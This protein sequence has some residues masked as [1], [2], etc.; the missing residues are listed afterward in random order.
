MT[1]RLRRRAAA[2][3]L[4][5]AVLAACNRQPISADRQNGSTPDSAEQVLYNASTVLTANGVRRGDMRGDTVG[6]FESMTR[7]RFRPVEVRFS[8][9]L[10]RPLAM[11]TAASGEYSLATGALVTTGS[12]RLVSDTS[13]RR[14]VTQAVL[15]DVETNQLASDSSFTATFGARKLSGVGFTSDPGL[16]TIQCVAKCVGSL[17]G[18]PNAGPRSRPPAPRPRPA[19]VRTPVPAPPPP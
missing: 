13:G 8:T 5:L 3:G 12:A 17:G 1:R 6:T 16:F 9:A 15:Y 10:G 4:T 14:I 2:A 19:P 7:F 11:L 18:P